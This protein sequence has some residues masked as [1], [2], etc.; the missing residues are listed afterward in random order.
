MTSD[1]II[2]I[3]ATNADKFMDFIETAMENDHGFDGYYLLT[4]NGQPTHHSDAHL[5]EE[6]HLSNFV[7][8]VQ[9]D[10]PYI[11]RC[12][13]DDGSVVYHGPF[14]NSDAAENW[15]NSRPEE[16]DLMEMDALMMNTPKE[17]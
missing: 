7:A 9:A 1:L 2:R 6:N 14:I 12:L 15:M 11:V 16:E 4:K 3:S 17:V 10:Y 8:A 13:Y 5:M